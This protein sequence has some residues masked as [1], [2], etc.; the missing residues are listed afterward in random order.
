MIRSMTGYGRGE[1]KTD[2]TRCIVEIRT[3]NH[4]NFD[5]SGKPQHLQQVN[6]LNP[7]Y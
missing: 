7:I 2:G 1:Y 4:K 5:Y 6:S 3:V